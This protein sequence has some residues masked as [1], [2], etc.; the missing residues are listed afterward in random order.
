MWRVFDLYRGGCACVWV[1]CCLWNTG[2]GINVCLFFDHARGFTLYNVV[3]LVFQVQKIALDFRV[4]NDLRNRNRI[5]Q[6]IK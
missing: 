5:Q 1:E 3:Q 6:E 2:V 4:K